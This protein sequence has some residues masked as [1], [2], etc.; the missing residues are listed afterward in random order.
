MQPRAEV[1]HWLFAAGFLFFALVLLAEAIV[2]PQVYRRRL[3]R[4]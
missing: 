1:A 4:A 2:G 3:W